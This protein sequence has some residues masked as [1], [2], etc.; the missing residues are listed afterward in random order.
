MGKLRCSQAGGH[1]PEIPESRVLG[2]P[3]L[4]KEFKEFK[5]CIVGNCL[6]K[7]KNKTPEAQ[8]D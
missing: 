7:K 4:H 5:A 6:R 1:R 2:K 3:E 8:K